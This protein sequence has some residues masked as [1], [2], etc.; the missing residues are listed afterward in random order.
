MV[1]LNS[2]LRHP[3]GH[4]RLLMPLN[5]WT[6]KGFTVHIE[7]IGPNCKDE[8]GLLLNNGDLKRDVCNSKDSL[9]FCLLLVLLLPFITRSVIKLIKDFTSPIN[10]RRLRTQILQEWSINSPEKESSQTKGLD[11]RKRNMKVDKGRRKICSYRYR[12][13]YVDPLPIYLSLYINYGLVISYRSENCS[14]YV[15]LIPRFLCTY[16]YIEIIFSFFLS[17][18]MSYKDCWLIVNFTV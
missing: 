7:V 5:Q 12:S 17:P 15:Y 3:P 9:A 6:K 18:D 1:L 16:L 14:N 11:K 4:F 10:E 13:I 8:I 2:N